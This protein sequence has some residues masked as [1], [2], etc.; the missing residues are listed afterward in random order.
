MDDTL[1]PYR[2]NRAVVT[3]SNLTDA[4]ND[5]QF[6]LTK[7]AAERLAALEFLRQTMY[8]YHPTT[9]RLQRVLTVAER[10]GS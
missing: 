4:P 3:V 10:T 8:G 2:V 1:P 5:T 9:T 6:W 7:S